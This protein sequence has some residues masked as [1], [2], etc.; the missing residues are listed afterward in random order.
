MIS[1][2]QNQAIHYQP[3]PFQMYVYL[4]PQNPVVTFLFQLTGLL[5]LGFILQPFLHRSTTLATLA[6]TVP[7]A[8]DDAYISAKAAAI[9]LGSQCFWYVCS[10]FKKIS[11]F[12]CFKMCSKPLLQCGIS[13]KHPH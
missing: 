9:S 7:V 3:L 4:I 5:F 8:N 1:H 6:S 13:P 10:S 11:I 2:A 12:N